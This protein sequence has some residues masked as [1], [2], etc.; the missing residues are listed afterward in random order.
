MKTNID[1]DFNSKKFLPK[2][3]K[4]VLINKETNQSYGETP[5]DLSDYAQLDQEVKNRQECLTLK[6][7]DQTNE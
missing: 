5:F 3:S 4:L 6:T 2:A 7:P 1:F